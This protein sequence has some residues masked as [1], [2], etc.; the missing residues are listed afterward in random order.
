[1]KKFAV[2]FTV[3]FI[4]FVVNS[5]A[6]DYCPDP[7]SGQGHFDATVIIPISFTYCPSDGDANLGTFV[8]C[9][10]A[11]TIASS[12]D[13]KFI[14]AGQPNYNFHYKIVQHLNDDANTGASITLTWKRISEYGGGTLTPG[15]DQ[16][17][18][19]NETG[20]KFTIRADPGT[21]TTGNT[22]GAKVFTQVVYA[23]YQG[24]L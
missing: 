7:V 9:A 11:Y 22:P 10:T 15:S 21:F 18:N 4:A 6:C 20:G 5:I 2:I 16:T 12:I 8:A 17:G 13:F 24:G 14:I 3:I 1:M 23:N 19:F